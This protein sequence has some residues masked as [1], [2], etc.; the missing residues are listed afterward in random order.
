MEEVLLWFRSK[1]NL[2]KNTG[3]SMAA[4]HTSGVNVPS[5]RADFDTEC[6]IGRISVWA[7]GEFDFEVL[8]R[9]DGEF[10]FFRHEST[11]T[12]EAPVLDYAYDEFVRSMNSVNNF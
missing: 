9:S 3:V 1:V 11:K 8:R 5:A 4:V 12:L 10:I 7:T 2:L 6:T